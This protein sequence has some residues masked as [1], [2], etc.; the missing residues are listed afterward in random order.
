MPPLALSDEQ[1]DAVFRAA[2][3]LRVADRDAFL[4]EEGG[5]GV[6]GPLGDWRRRYPPRGHDG[7][8]AALGGHPRKSAMSRLC[9]RRSN[10]PAQMQVNR[11]NKNL[12][13][14]PTRQKL[15]ERPKRKS[16]NQR[17]PR[18]KKARSALT[19]LDHLAGSAQ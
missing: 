2:R 8:K 7:A 4:Q 9:E 16:T 18:Y 13:T 5:R 17:A 11:E 15:G 3:P 10:R 14:G 6:A 19:K 12:S 1:M